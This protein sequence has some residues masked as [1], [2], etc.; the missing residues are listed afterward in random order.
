MR[1]ALDTN[2]LIS[3]FRPCEDMHPHMQQ[4][5]RMHK[6]GTIELHISL[7]SINQIVKDRNVR[8]Y[9][10]SLS[11]IP[12][13]PAGSWAE[14]VGTWNTVVGTWQ[15]AKRSNQVLR[16]IGQLANK[17]ADIRDKQIVIDSYLGGMQVLITNDKALCS[18]GPAA[19]LKAGLGLLITDPAGFVALYGPQP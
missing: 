5:D 18:P 7:K 4:I 3:L 2:C 6:A 11:Q 12:N 16:M 1:V 17:G 10:E 8:K 14:Q 19:K 15:G 9:A 13:Y